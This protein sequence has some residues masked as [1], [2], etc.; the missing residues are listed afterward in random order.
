MKAQQVIA[1]VLKDPKKIEVEAALRLTIVEIGK[2]MI[3]KNSI[4]K[5]K[6]N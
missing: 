4:A 3:E 5:T 6:S 2:E 1:K